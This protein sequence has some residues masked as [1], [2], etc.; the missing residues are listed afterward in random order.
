[1]NWYTIICQAL[2]A[3]Q[4]TRSGKW[5]KAQRLMNT[6]QHGDKNE[7]IRNQSSIIKDEQR[8]P[9]QTV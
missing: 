2:W 9:R 5:R 3:T 8:L 7:S 4:L 6:T 1:M